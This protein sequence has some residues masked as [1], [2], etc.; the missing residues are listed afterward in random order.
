VG[1]K[2][3]GGG[4]ERCWGWEDIESQEYRGSLDLDNIKVLKDGKEKPK[5]KTLG[6]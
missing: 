1:S 2:G 6:F 4:E 5:K 3:G